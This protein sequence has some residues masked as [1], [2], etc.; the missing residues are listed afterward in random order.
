MR[1]KWIIG[2]GSAVLLAIAAAALSRHRVPAAPHPATVSSPAPVAPAPAPTEVQLEGKVEA[3]TVVPVPVVVDGQLANLSADVGQEVFEGQVLAMISSPQLQ[4]DQANAANDAGQAQSRLNSLEADLSQARLDVERSNADLIRA[5]AEAD[6][7]AKIFE[8]QQLLS[9]D[10]ATPRLV[11]EKAEREY[12]AGQTEVQSLTDA[13]R[14]ASDRVST[15]TAEIENAKR[16]FEAKKEQFERVKA[17]GAAAEV[18]SPVTGIVVAR[19]GQVGDQVDTD[20]KALFEIAVDLS[21]LKVVLEPKANDL[22]KL[23]PGQTALVR[24]AENGRGPLSGFVRDVHDGR[25]VVEFQNPN[26]AVKPG[27]TAQVQIKL[28]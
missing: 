11:Y 21:Q 19:H 8:R 20:T 22:A 24:I 9:R 14:Q 2:A 26:P 28:T 23:R 13:A 3:R 5:R 10:G 27:F 12:R 17:V 4:T 15:L 6:R 16:Q 18:H 1:G 25:V 7:L